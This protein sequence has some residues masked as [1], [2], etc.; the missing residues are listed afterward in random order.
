M[1]STIFC[2]VTSCDLVKLIDVSEERVASIYLI[3][4][5]TEKRA[6]TISSSPASRPQGREPD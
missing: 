4:E 6:T 3:E 1:K 2:D 5:Q